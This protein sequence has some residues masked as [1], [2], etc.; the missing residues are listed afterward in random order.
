MKAHKYLDDSF[1]EYVVDA[2]RYIIDVELTWSLAVL[3]DSTLSIGVPDIITDMA[4]LLE[5]EA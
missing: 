2:L 5:A 3:L 4:D 1:Q